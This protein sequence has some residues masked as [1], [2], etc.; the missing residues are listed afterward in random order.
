[1]TGSKIIQAQKMLRKLIPAMS[2]QI[3]SSLNGYQ[4]N[5][6]LKPDRETQTSG[7]ETRGVLSLGDLLGVP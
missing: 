1:M 6:G 3:C 2:R 7:Q 5:E 4:N